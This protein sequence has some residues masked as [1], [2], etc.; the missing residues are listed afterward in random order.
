MLF[1]LVLFG[2]GAANGGILRNGR[3]QVICHRTA[4]RDLPENTLEALALAARMG[5]DVIEVD[6][7]RMLDG[8]LVLN[9]DNYLVS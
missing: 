3:V 1:L 5:C 8:E 4:N 6:I 2:S 9:H 7:T